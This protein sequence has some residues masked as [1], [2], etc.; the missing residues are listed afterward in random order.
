MRNLTLGDLKLA[1]RDLLGAKIEML[2]AS[3]TGKL[4]E[5]R[6]RAKQKA[7][8]A[9]PEGALKTAPLA[10]ELSEM[11]GQH[12]GFGAAIFYIGEAVAAHPKLSKAVKEAVKEAQ[13]IFVPQL[14][15]LR[16]PYADEAAAALD[17]RPELARIRDNLK[18]VAVPGGGSL[19]DWVKG[20][21]AAGDQLDK[22]L[23]QRATLLAGAENASSSAP[24]RSSTVGLLGRF[25]DALRDELE[26]DENQIP[27]NHEAMLFAYIDKLSADRASSA[28]STQAP[29]ASVDAGAS[30]AGSP[31]TSDT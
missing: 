29:E 24:L 27:R 5:P 9:I 3:A 8:E 11:D 21:L 6:L 16:A 17:N 30:G 13:A 25:R 1:L 23:R 7:I 19:L 4:Y 15:V 12:D 14:G 10:A 28:S 26:D 18:A 22:L 2:R 31:E 20:F